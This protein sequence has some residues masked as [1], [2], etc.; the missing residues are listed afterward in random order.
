MH[1][2]TMPKRASVRHDSGPFNPRTSGNA[3]A[4]GSRRLS[5]ES[6]AVTDARSDILCLMVLAVKPGASVGT[7]KPR[8]PSSVCAHTTATSA[9]EPFVIHIFE[10]LSIQSSPSRRARVRMLPGSDPW[11]DSVRPKQPIAAPAAIRGSH[12][13]LCSSEPQRQIA[14][15]AREPWTDTIDLTPE[16]HCLLYTSDAAD[17][18]TRV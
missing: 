9:M 15:M 18:L 10:P 14:Y 12:S 11:S 7:T 8:I 6:S 1:P 4:F 13:S 5:K 3:A 17:D 16:S 2:H